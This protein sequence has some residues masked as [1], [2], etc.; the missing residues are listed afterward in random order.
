MVY[1][2]EEGA[3]SVE[4]CL[5]KLTQQE[6]VWRP[7]LDELLRGDLTPLCDLL[8][9]DLGNGIDAARNTIRA[10]LWSY[11]PQL[12]PRPARQGLTP[13][14]RKRQYI[15]VVSVCFNVSA[16]Q[17]SMRADK[18]Q[19]RQ[20]WLADN[21]RGPLRIAS[22][23]CYRDIRHAIAQIAQLLEQH[24]KPT[25]VD[26]VGGE[27]ASETGT[28]AIAVNSSLNRTVSRRTAILSLTATVVVVA[29]LGV[30]LLRPWEQAEPTAQRTDFPIKI[31]KTNPLAGAEE[32][33]RFVFSEPL[34][35]SDEELRAFN[36]ETVLKSR[37]LAPWYTKHGGIPVDSG[38]TV[39]T[40]RGNSDET[41]RI[42]DLRAVKDCQEPFNGTYFQGYT[43]GGPSENLKLGIDLDSPDS[44]LSELA[45]TMAKGLHPSG[46]NYF[47]TNTVDLDPRERIS[48]TIAA[49]TKQYGCDFSLE[50]D[51]LTENGVVTQ[52]IDDNGKPFRV[53]AFANSSEGD[54]PFARYEVVYAQDAEYTWR[55]VDPE[56]YGE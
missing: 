40:L 2:P 18:L 22:S 20:K 12:D 56:S 6:G 5:T 17:D 46:P 53:T 55:Q 35:M 42:V 19:D 7:D 37:N 48:I 4:E 25:A 47:A 21:E 32:N 14:Q 41:V 27:S 16:E 9:I 33:V 13:D 45:Y 8:A 24:A 23:I 36:E 54:A 11:I 1:R 52:L 44:T 28:P 38:I 15:K 34:E 30:A 29:A 3:L 39:I 26:E 51:V 31:E 43:Q 50:M 49:F 10:R